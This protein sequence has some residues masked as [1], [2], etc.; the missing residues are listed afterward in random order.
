MLRFWIEN[1]IWFR[2]RD[3]EPLTDVQQ[4]YADEMRSHR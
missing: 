1:E 4:E 3:G 2:T